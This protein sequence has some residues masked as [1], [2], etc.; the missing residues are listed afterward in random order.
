MRQPTIPLNDV[1][2]LQQELSHA[3]AEFQ[4]K[5]DLVTSLQVRLNK[6]HNALFRAIGSSNPRR[7]KITDPPKCGF[8]P[9]GPP[10]F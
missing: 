9:R 10:R 7:E 8:R 2:E 1:V 6:I 4:A 3:R 5:A